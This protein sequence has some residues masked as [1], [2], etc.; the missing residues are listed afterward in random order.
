MDYFKHLE[1]QRRFK[2]AMRVAPQTDAQHPRSDVVEY[3]PNCPEL[4]FL[5][6]DIR[7]WILRVR[8]GIV[9]RIR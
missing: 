3:N 5:A 7:L 4:R 2:R 6:T 9:S 8:K 1:Q